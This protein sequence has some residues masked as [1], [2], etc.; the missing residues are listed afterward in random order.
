[1]TNS[2]FSG[3]RAGS[4]S[5]EGFGGGI[6]SSGTLTVTNSTFSG[7][8]ASEGGGI[9]NFGTG[10]L[11][12]TNSTF[13]GNRATGGATGGRGGGIASSGTLTV[14]NSTFSGN[15]ATGAGGGIRNF[16]TATLKNTIIANSISGGDCVGTL[17]DAKNNLIQNSHIACNLS[18]GMNGNII[19]LDPNLG[20]LTGSPAYFPLNPGSPAMDKGDNATCAAPPVNNQ[21]QNGV[22]RPQDGDLN[23]TA[24][25]DI[26]AYERSPYL[27]LPFISR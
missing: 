24:V 11:T 15:S 3:N 5:T 21:S 26:G 12:V 9:R 1:M 22:T 8:R 19:G 16:G 7:N 20:A 10:K 18:N 13:S 27:Y 25:C 23:G 4:D 6:A 14:T 17:S 2:T